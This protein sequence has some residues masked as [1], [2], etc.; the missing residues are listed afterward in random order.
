MQ[1][2]NW[3]C[4]PP[5]TD[6]HCVSLFPAVYLKS[7]QIQHPVVHADAS[8]VSELDVIR[9]DKVALPSPSFE[10]REIQHV[11]TVII[12]LIMDAFHYARS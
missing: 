7:A 5:C 1:I 6:S 4:V 3:D 10:R 9:H 12:R 8:V 11:Q 2:E